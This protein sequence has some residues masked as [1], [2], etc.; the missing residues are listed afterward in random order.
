MFTPSRRVISGD[1]RATLSDLVSMGGI[2]MVGSCVGTSPSSFSPCSF[3]LSLNRSLS[4][5]T[6]YP[7]KAAAFSCEARRKKGSDGGASLSQPK[8]ASMLFPAQRSAQASPPFECNIVSQCSVP[9]S[10]WVEGTEEGC[11]SSNKKGGV[12]V[13]FRPFLFVRVLSACRPRM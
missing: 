3:H 7:L 11:C 5:T 13:L 4:L 6:S 8:R 10:L 1:G 2:R 12:L 9:F